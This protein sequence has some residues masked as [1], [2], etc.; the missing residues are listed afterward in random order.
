MVDIYADDRSPR[1]GTDCIERME[2]V[3]MNTSVLKSFFSVQ[4]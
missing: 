1:C 4:K 2:T 3:S